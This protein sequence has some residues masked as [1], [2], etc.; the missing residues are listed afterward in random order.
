MKK[1]LI[2]LS[3]IVSSSTLYSQNTVNYKVVIDDPS[4]LPKVVVNLDLFGMEVWQPK[5]DFGLNFGFGVWGH[6]EIPKLPLVAQ[7]QFYRSYFED[8]TLL[9]DEEYP[10]TTHFQIGGV[11]NLA[12][13]TKRKTIGVGL[14]NKVVSSEYSTNTMGDR[15]ET[16]TSELTSI[17]VPANV[18]KQFGIRGGLIFRNSGIAFE[19][20]LGEPPSQFADKPY[21]FANHFSTNIYAGIESRK[22][23]NLVLI[24][25]KYGRTTTG[26][27]AT[28]VFADAILPIVNNFTH[29]SGDDIQQL[30]KDS[31]SGFPVGFRIG[32][33][34]NPV[35]KRE[36]TKK[37]FGL[38]TRGEVG[39]KPFTGWYAVA[40]L[41]INIIKAK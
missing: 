6:V 35:E 17:N 15:V 38:A 12:D 2:L 5:T 41:G 13:N 1:F 4:N 34:N 7:Y 32:L 18:R 26:S 23:T 37:K 10:K 21:Q 14:D 31:L 24:T 16:R 9:V 29:P 30:M 20:G 11:F 33:Q 25:D 36:Y 3:V 39:Y 22:I 40:T 28:S 8:A 27:K 19:E